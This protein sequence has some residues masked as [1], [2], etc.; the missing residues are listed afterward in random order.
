MELDPT[1]SIGGIINIIVLLI[2]MF[3]IVK[4]LGEIETKVEAMW[5]VFMKGKYS[6]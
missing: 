1:I 2:G 5:K 6:E 3:S 4:K